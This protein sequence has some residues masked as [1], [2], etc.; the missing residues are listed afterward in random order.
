MV[1]VGEEREENG[2]GEGLSEREP[3]LPSVS[4]SL[5][6]QLIKLPPG[7]GLCCLTQELQGHKAQCGLGVS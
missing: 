1:G 4:F 7:L 2:E 5:Q 3:C 6:R